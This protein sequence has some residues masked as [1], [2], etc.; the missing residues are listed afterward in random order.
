MGGFVE[1]HLSTILVHLISILLPPPI[2][3]KHLLQPVHLL[4][5]LLVLASSLE[6]SFHDAATSRLQLQV[7]HTK[8]LYSPL[9][10]DSL[11]G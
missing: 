11:L 9:T 4:V 8:S 1:S 2:F 5:L 10:S 7:V 3:L 6:S